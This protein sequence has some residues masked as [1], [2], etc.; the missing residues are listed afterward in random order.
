M[1]EV[2]I[3]K[4]ASTKQKAIIDI[5]KAILTK[6]NSYKETMIEETAIDNLLYEFYEMSPEEVSVIEG[7]CP[8]NSK[9]PM[10]RC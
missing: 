9:P 2:P 10:L 1:T 6:K 5:V 7:G 3:K 8:S 4:L